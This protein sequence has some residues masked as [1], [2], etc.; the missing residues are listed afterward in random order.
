MDKDSLLKLA[1][2]YYSE[3]EILELEHAI[4]FA[5]KAHQGQKRKSGEPYI[6]HPLAVAALIVEW[7]MDIDTVLA[8]VLHDTVE[9]TD[10]T[11]DDIESLFGRDVV[12]LKI[13]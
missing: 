4:D 8:A 12:F 1:K 10:V 5:T 13:I 6:I 7:E 9:D 11:L 3:D 2:N